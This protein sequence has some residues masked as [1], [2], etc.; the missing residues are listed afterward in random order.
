MNTINL[1]CK[2][3]GTKFSNPI[4]L[5]SGSLVED[6]SKVKIFLDTKTGALVP[7]TTR[8]KY[9]P[10]RRR[11]PSRHLQLN[12][13]DGWIRNCEWTG[14]IINYWLPYL[15]ELAKTERVIMSVSGRNID[16][17]LKVCQ[18][19]DNFNFPLLEINVSCAHS[20]EAHGFITRSKSHIIKLIGALKEKIDTPIALKLGHS[21]FIVDLAKAAEGA[22]VDAIVTINTLGPVLD[23]DV[24]SG[25]PELTLGINSGKGGLSG[26]MIFHTALT[27]VAELA[28]VLKIPIIAC[29]GVAMP[30]E[31]V[32]MIMAGASAVQIY[33][34]A[35][36]AGNQA[37]VFLNN[38]IKMFKNWLKAHNYTDVSQIKGLLL[39]KLSRSHQMTVLAPKFNIKFCTKCKDC[40]NI[41][42]KNS[43]SL[44]NNSIS[45]NKEKCI[46]CGACVSVCPAGALK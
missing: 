36:L 8:L 34:A 24:E 23:F 17:C 10:G 12:I 15:E 29:G 4:W 27:D 42:L 28:K 37:P 45:I 44:V 20:N 32:K 13:N 1:S 40:I 41:C 2:I 38:F 21:D 33:S 14:N 35:H 30:E 18:T 7:R 46:G 6:Y 39:P 16:D 11:H 5:G 25:K 43:I 9:E 3:L 26:R 22:G 31:A 19:L